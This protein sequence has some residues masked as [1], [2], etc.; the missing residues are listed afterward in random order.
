MESLLAY[1]CLQPQDEF[2]EHVQEQRQGQEVAQEAVQEAEHGES[3]VEENVKELHAQLDDGVPAVGEEQVRVEQ[4]PENKTV[5]G[6][7]RVENAPEHVHDMFVDTGAEVTDKY[8]FVENDAVHVLTLDSVSGSTYTFSSPSC[9]LE[10]V[11]LRGKVAS[12]LVN[13]TYFL[14]RQMSGVWTY[15][16]NE[17]C[18]VLLRPVIKYTNFVSSRGGTK[19]VMLA[20][21]ADFFQ[22]RPL[23]RPGY[24]VKRRSVN[25]R[26]K[27]GQ[28]LRDHLA[29]TISFEPESSDVRVVSADQIAVLGCD[30][31]K[32]DGLYV[33]ACGRYDLGKCQ[34]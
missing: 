5:E 34:T 26:F 7:E 6:G 24:E 8:V 17:E 12:I 30:F 14:C 9:T 4:Q 32:L 29:Y 20:G 13:N 16:N 15:T 25:S 1:G 18:R 3:Q 27:D 22:D 33:S 11:V 21:Y 2:V 19:T 10:C 31:H 28:S 23:H